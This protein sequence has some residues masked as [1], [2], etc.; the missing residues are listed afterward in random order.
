MESRIMH[1]LSQLKLVFR[2]W[3]YRLKL[4]RDEIKFLRSFLKPGDVVVDIGA[5]K[6]AYAYWMNRAVGRRGQIFLFEPQP[7]LVCELRHTLEAP[8]SN[9][10]V[11]QA[12]LSSEP[13]VLTLHIPTGGPSPGATFEADPSDD[14]GDQYDVAVET[15]DR[16][17]AERLDSPIRLIKC[18]VEGHELEVFRGGEKILTQNRPAILFECEQ[19]HH[20]EDSIQDVFRYLESLGYE[21]Q[22]FPGQEPRPIREFD[23]QAHQSTSG[24]KYCNNFLFQH[25]AA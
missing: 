21:G 14:S 10:T 12:G 22:F 13:G 16:F 11:T 7:E 15:L 17:F 1:F 20:R 25:P 18:D 5:H 23:L 6:G 2:A 8:H 19:R 24:L 3:R 9:V 4:D